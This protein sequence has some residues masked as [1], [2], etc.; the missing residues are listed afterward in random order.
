MDV[1]KEMILHVAKTARLKLTEEEILEFLPQLKE[2]LV[3]FEKL[4]DVPTENVK[5]SY[6][7]IPVSAS[8]REDKPEI[9]LTQEE[10]LQN[11][12]PNTQDNYFKGPK[13][14]DK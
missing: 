3:A 14:L 13:V 4:A 9:S 6:H 11:A 12:Q 8:Y 1:T 5:P 2:I 7:A 10:A